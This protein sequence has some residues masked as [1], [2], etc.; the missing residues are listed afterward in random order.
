MSK[1]ILLDKY[2]FVFAKFI[3]RLPSRHNL[4]INGVLIK[5]MMLTLNNGGKDAH[6]EE[7]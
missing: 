5:R 2:G 7:F 4:L 1:A 3:I 6:H